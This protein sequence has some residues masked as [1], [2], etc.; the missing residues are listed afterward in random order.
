MP[1]V[2]ALRG[3]E[4]V[5]GVRIP[6]DSQPNVTTAKATTRSRI[7]N[8]VFFMVFFMAFSRG[9]ESDFISRRIFVLTAGL[10]NCVKGRNS[11]KQIKFLLSEMGQSENVAFSQKFS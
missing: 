4:G 5:A 3:H 9:L 7:Y 10:G 1:K 2:S 6:K 8:I 11:L